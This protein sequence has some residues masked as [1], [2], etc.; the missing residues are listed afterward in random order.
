MLLPPGDDGRE[1]SSRA[2]EKLPAGLGVWEVA[3]R[4][5]SPADA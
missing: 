3:R 4:R 5:V 1:D 2:E